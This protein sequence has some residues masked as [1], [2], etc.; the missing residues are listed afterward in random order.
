MAPFQFFSDHID[1]DIATATREGRRREFAA[2]AEFR[3]REVPDPQD[4]ATFEASK[5][6]RTG[7]P[8]G[9]RDLYAELLRARRDLPPGDADAIDFDEH[10]GWLRVRRGPYVLVANFSRATGPRAARR[11]GRAGASPPSHVTLEPGYV[12]AAPAVRRA[13]AARVSAVRAVWPGR[14]FPLGASLG[15][16]RDELLAVLRARGAGRAVPVRRGRQRGARRG[17]RAHRVQLARLPARRR[18][19][20]ALRLPRPRA[21]RPAGRP[22][23]QPG[24]AADRP[25]REVDRGQ[26]A[27]EPRERAPVR[28]AT[29]RRRRRRPRARRRGLRGRDPQVRR[30]RRP[31]RLGGRP[32]PGHAVRPHG[33]LRDARQGLHD[34][35]SRRARGPARHVRGPGVR[36]RDR[37]PAVARRH[38]RRAAADPPH[39]RRVVPRRARAHQLLGLLDDRLPGAALRLRRDR[40]P[41]PGGA[42]VQ[43]HGQGPAPGRASR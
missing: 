31:L 29:R 22:P 24:Q 15:R 34:A 6:T 23:L 20:P 5:L 28:A 40:H 9:L 36:G 11:H 17:L 21:V 32:P 13:G 25:V 1:E 14:P 41:R 42:R 39:R 30:H 37:A 4:P 2:F 38:R 26:G 16:E 10:A 18:S 43:G 7:E 33:D 12:V 35:P 19:R 27:L 3:G 8:A